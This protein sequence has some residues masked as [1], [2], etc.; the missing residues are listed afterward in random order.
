MR[1]ISVL[2]YLIEFC[3]VVVNFELVWRKYE[4]ELVVKE[5]E[6]IR[7]EIWYIGYN[8]NQIVCNMNWEMVV[9]E[10][11]EYLVVIVVWNCVLL[12]VEVC[13]IINGFCWIDI[14]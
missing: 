3:E 1:G 5:F 11:D 6:V 4:I 2:C 7:I 14:K 10:R 8:I 12:F 13:E 9:D